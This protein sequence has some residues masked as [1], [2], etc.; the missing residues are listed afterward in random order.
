[1]ASRAAGVPLCNQTRSCTALSVNSRLV[2]HK[3]LCLAQWL[4]VQIKL[5][6]HGLPTFAQYTEHLIL[7][8]DHEQLRPKPN[9]YELQAISG[10]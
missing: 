1:M 8:G 2:S 6:A 3:I 4:H 9:V 10:R 7:I 5:H